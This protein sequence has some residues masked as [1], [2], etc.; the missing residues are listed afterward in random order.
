MI[1]LRL[2][3]TDFCLPLLHNDPQTVDN[4]I[5]Q[6]QQQQQPPNDEQQNKH[7]QQ[8]RLV[9]LMVRAMNVLRDYPVPEAMVA[10]RKLY[11]QLSPGGVV[12]EGSAETHGRIVV[13]L[14]LHKPLQQQ[15]HN[16]NNDNDTDDDEEEEIPIAAVVFAADLEAL[17]R[18]PAYNNN[19]NTAPVSVADWFNRHNHL[20]RLYR[21][22][23]DTA[24]CA[25]DQVPLWAAPMRSFLARWKHTATKATDATP[26]DPNNDHD[27]DDDGTEQTRTTT[28]TITIQERFR[29]SVL[30]LQESFDEEEGE[31]GD[32]IVTEWVDEG[33]VVW[34]PGDK[35][36]LL[37]P[38]VEEWQCYRQRVT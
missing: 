24:D 23:C 6:Q 28:T 3:T 20:P 5:Q 4:D 31:G 2:G 15:Q 26:P 36:P 35:R 34:V 29:K 22:Y 19:N 32:T 18:D 1:S 13:A 8:Q 33:I 30:T 25:E 9:V 7:Q 37:L 12:V 11:Q 14:L 16:N 27:K 10:L 17:A 38:D 21:S